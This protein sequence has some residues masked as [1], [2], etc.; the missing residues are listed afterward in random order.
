MLE[1]SVAGIRRRRP[2]GV[3]QLESELGVDVEAFARTLRGRA[4]AGAIEALHED[5]GLLERVIGAAER[6]SE[7][8]RVPPAPDR[9]EL[10][11][12]FWAAATAPA[13]NGGRS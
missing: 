9:A 10:R 7:L 4:G 1:S 11:A 3:E 8:E 12:I 6:R 13:A 2:E 5:P